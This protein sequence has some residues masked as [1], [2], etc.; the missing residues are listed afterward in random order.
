MVH[1]DVWNCL[2]YCWS[3]SVR[4]GMETGKHLQKTFALANPNRISLSIKKNNRQESMDSPQ[5][6]RQMEG[7][8]SVLVR[9]TP[10]RA[11]RV[12]DS[13]VWCW[14]ECWITR[15]GSYL[16]SQIVEFLKSLKACFG[17]LLQFCCPHS[18]LICWASG[19]CFNRCILFFHVC[20]ICVLY[21]SKHCSAFI[22]NNTVGFDF[23]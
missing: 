12:V 7:I 14:N 16:C 22:R 4:C 18:P 21:T 23:R 17:K 2:V 3:A 8:L 1:P 15:N 11:E 6:P 13:A 20:T 10:M 5:F 9:E 19:Y